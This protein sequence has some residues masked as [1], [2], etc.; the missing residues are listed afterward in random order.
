VH[1]AAYFQKDKPA[2][3]IDGDPNRSVTGWSK[4]GTLPFKVVDE[5]QAA[6]FSRD[7]E[8]IVIDTQARPTREDLEALA[9][10]CDLLVVP[11]TPDAMALEALTLMVDTLKELDAKQYRVLLT[12]IPPKPRKDGDAARSAL[13]EAGLPLFQTGIREYSAFQKAANLGVPVYDVKDPKASMGWD[14]YRS[15]AMEVAQ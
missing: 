2:L 13:E 9:G 6:R 11:T 1:L 10:G 8:H 5:R 12:V 15:V 4:R 14:D 7:F 3:L